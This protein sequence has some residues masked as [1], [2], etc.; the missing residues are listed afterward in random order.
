MK[1]VRRAFGVVAL[2]AAAMLPFMEGTAQ[3][4][5]GLDLEI[6]CVE[7][8]NRALL[9]VTVN[10]TCPPGTQPNFSADIEVFGIQ[11]SGHQ[12]ATGFGGIG[13]LVCDG[14]PQTAVIQVVPEQNVPFS[15]GKINLGAQLSVC[16]VSCES[17]LLDL[18]PYH[19]G[20]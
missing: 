16:D 12:I 4:Q 10:Y 9:E 15:G 19:F 5:E 14:T 7:R 1:H 3:A 18:A 13:D 8:V 20:C 11:A 2:L 6:V 17:L